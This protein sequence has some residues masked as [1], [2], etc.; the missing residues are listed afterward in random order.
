MHS[1][2]R[3][4][5][6]NS[7][8]VAGHRDLDALQSAAPAILGSLNRDQIFLAFPIYEPAKATGWAMVCSVSPVCLQQAVSSKTSRSCGA[9]IMAILPVGRKPR[10][11]RE[12]VKLTVEVTMKKTNKTYKTRIVLGALL[13]AAGAAGISG[14]QAADDANFCMDVELGPF[15]MVPGPEVEPGACPVRDYLDGA[16]QQA[17][18]PFT[19]EDHP[20]NCETADLVTLPV[21]G[22]V[23]TWVVSEG[24]ITGTIGG[25]AF[26]AMLYCA[27]LTNW[28]GSFC[29][30]P[31]D[32]ELPCFQLAQPFLGKGLPFPRV[33]EVSVLDGVITVERG[34]KQKEV[35]LPI[36]MATRAAGITHVEGD[37]QVGASITHSLLGMLALEDNDKDE[38]LAGSAD[39]LL[40][41]HIFS[42]YTVDNDPGP[43]VIKG[44]ICSQD[45]YKRLNKPGPKDK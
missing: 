43:A 21:V 25:H 17:F 34:S 5:L 4:Q 38:V 22:M 11:V 10:A 8:Q 26:S 2:E 20:F 35:E 7:A 33:T 9:G 19:I 28:Y 42:P 44:A 1:V 30:D 40:Q 12:A 31:T 32:P 15:H 6:A 14:A 3:P 36:I 16:L 39:L 37:G 45:L 27:S 29:P 41:G 23:P 18:Y 13:L 24:E